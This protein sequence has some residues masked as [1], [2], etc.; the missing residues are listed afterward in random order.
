M[1]Y[2]PY[3]SSTKL[4]HHIG[5]HTL[6]GPLYHWEPNQHARVK[7]RRVLTIKGAYM[8]PKCPLEFG[9]QWSMAM[10]DGSNLEWKVSFFFFFLTLT[11]KPVEEDQVFMFLF[12]KG[13]VMFIVKKEVTNN[14]M[15]E[16]DRSG[17]SCSH[18]FIKWLKELESLLW[19]KHMPL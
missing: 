6:V 11:R 10:A 1:N 17:P 3:C 18:K 12:F 7:T 19:N 8:T 13:K 2:R 9:R 16:K 5:V 4:G 14:S 15:G